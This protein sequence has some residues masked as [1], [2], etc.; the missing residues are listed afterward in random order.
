MTA[1]LLELD[2]AVAEK[3]ASTE[4]RASRRCK[5]KQMVR[6]RPS[7]PEVEHFEEIRG[8]TSIS[9]S[10]VYFQA[11]VKAYQLSMR[12]FVTLPYSE[13]PTALNKEYLAEVVR[14]DKLENGTIGVGIKLLMDMGFKAAVHPSINPRR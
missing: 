12:L 11:R 9:R 3:P 4:R 7:D 8:T 1:R 6:V 10:G 5:L 2:P 13:Q 14:L